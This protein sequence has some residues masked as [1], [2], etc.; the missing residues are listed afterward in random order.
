MIE[1]RAIVKRFGDF[2]ALDG[3]SV[4]VP[5]GSLTALLGPSGSGKSTLLRV[6]A[7]LEQPDA[8]TVVRTPPALT[9]GYLPQEPGALSGETL[10]AYLARRTGAAGRFRSGRRP[11]RNAV[12]GSSSSSA[13]IAILPA[14]ASAATLAAAALPARSATSRRDSSSR[15]FFPSV[16]NAQATSSPAAMARRMRRTAAISSS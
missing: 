7:G 6:I 12:A 14:A 15:R 8:G 5:T 1:A 11:G 16:R 9:V 2:T 10:R 4:D 13:G 3:V